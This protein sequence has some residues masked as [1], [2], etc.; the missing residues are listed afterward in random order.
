MDS[1][2][3]AAA[4][5]FLIGFIPFLEIYLAVPAAVALGLDNVSAVFW[6]SLGNFLPVV[7]IAL[8][9]ERLRRIPRIGAWLERRAST[10]FQKLI[11]RHGSWF[12]LLITPLIGS[13]AVAVTGVVLGMNR[14]TL[15]IFSGLSILLYAVVIVTA[16][17]FGFDIGRVPEGVSEQNP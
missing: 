16:L 2:I 11:D 3:A 14:R 5:S 15:I 7:I 10:R 13:W 9:F 6:P 17:A 12:V 1:Y 4:S 8:A